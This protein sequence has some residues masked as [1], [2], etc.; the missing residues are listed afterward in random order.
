MSQQLKIKHDHLLYR[1][2]CNT[3][4]AFWQSKDKQATVHITLVW[5]N[6]LKNNLKLEKQKQH[7]MLST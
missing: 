5:L 4:S 2:T 1:K 6:W 3:L 7:V